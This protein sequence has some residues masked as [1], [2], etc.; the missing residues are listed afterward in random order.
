MIEVL[1]IGLVI[2][3]ILLST[4]LLTMV[5]QRMKVLKCLWVMEDI[6]IDILIP[7][8]PPSR[9]CI[10]YHISYYGRCGSRS[11]AT[12]QSSSLDFAVDHFGDYGISVSRSKDN[13]KYSSL[14]RGARVDFDGIGGHRYQKSHYSYHN[15]VGHG[16]WFSLSVYSC[17]VDNNV[18]GG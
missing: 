1:D 2:P 18:H 5:L 8:T 3:D 17:F 4:I 11:Q 7:A 9:N 15:P 10:V 14:N 6:D 16:K 13:S 12:S